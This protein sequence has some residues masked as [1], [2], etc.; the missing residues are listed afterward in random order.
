MGKN[1]PTVGEGGKAPLESVLGAGRL[2]L[3]W[4]GNLSEREL[5]ADKQLR[6]AIE[7]QFEV[8]AEALV[9][10][11]NVDEQTWN[12][13]ADAAT[14]IRLGDAIRRDYDAIDYGILWRA[15]RK[16][17]PELIRQVQTLLR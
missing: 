13:I 1:S 17:L 8:I 15:T 11:R 4:T 10:L 2:V 3:E 6:A 7:R 12:H 9:R 14:A 16:E 5:W